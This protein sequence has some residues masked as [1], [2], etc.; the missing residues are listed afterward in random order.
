MF[1]L[2]SVGFVNQAVCFGWFILFLFVYVALVNKAFCFVLFMLN[3]P[4]SSDRGLSISFC[5]HL[6]LYMH[7]SKYEVI[8]HFSRKK[9]LIILCTSTIGKFVVLPRWSLRSLKLDLV[10]IIRALCFGFKPA[11]KV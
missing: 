11:I 5:K 6:S 7:L 3:E 1:L 2:V 8:T 10:T 9:F 4:I